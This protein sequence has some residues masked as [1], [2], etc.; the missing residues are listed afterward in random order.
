MISAVL[1]S[2]ILWGVAASAATDLLTRMALKRLPLLEG[3]P[4]T[5]ASVSIINLVILAKTGSY[6]GS[7]P[8]FIYGIALQLNGLKE[9]YAAMTAI[10]KT[11][12]FLKEEETKTNV[13]LK[14]DEEELIKTQK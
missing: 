2:P 8:G 5:G 11:I 1:N 13:A 6:S 12:A 4:L 14:K 9:N 10:K 3:M 7:L